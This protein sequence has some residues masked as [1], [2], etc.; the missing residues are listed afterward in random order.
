VKPDPVADL[1]GP[2]GAVVVRL[3]RGGQIGFGFA[4]RAGPYKAAL[5]LL[6]DLQDAALG[7]GIKA[8]LRPE[9]DIVRVAERAGGLSHSMRRRER[10]YHRDQERADPVCSCRNHAMTLTRSFMGRNTWRRGPPAAGASK[11]ETATNGPG[12]PR[13]YAPF[14]SCRVP[15]WRYGLLVQVMSLS[16]ATD[17]WQN[18][19]EEKGNWRG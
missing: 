19:R 14:G 6:D 15:V 4:G 13:A 18:E 10:E 1:E 8:R 11:E 17:R 2:D 9:P 3:P 12:R 16:Q 5:D 7:G